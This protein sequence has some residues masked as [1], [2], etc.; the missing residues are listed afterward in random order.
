MDELAGVAAAA[1]IGMQLST[2]SDDDYHVAETVGKPQ[3]I[4]PQMTWR[5]GSQTLCFALGRVSIDGVD[6]V[7]IVFWYRDDDGKLTAVERSDCATIGYLYGGTSCEGYSDFDSR[8]KLMRVHS[9]P[10]ALHHNNQDGFKCKLWKVPKSEVAGQQLEHDLF[11][12]QIARFF[13]L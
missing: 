12:L 6:K 13:S 2:E 7:F 10:L 11:C 4:G 9:A 3:F 5:G 8:I 1:V